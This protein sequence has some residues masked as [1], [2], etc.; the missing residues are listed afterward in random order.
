[1]DSKTHA[2]S[3]ANINVHD[4]IGNDVIQFRRRKYALFLRGIQAQYFTGLSCFIACKALSIYLHH[5]L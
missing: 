4:A 2:V 5:Y 3:T 1:M